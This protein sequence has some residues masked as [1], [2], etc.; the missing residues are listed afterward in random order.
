MNVLQTYLAALSFGSISKFL[1]I[2]SNFIVIYLLN[3]TIGKAG[4]GLFLFSISILSIVALIVSSGITQ[5]IIFRVSKLSSSI[6]DEESQARAFLGAG[7]ACNASLALIV[8]IL[9]YSLLHV[10]EGVGVKPDLISCLY[11]TAFIIFFDVI[12]FSVSAWC[13]GYHQVKTAIFLKELAPSILLPLFI[14]LSSA[15]FST[16]DLYFYFGLSYSLSY[17]V[18]P[19]LFL[20][21]QRPQFLSINKFVR[22]DDASYALKSFATQLTA[23]PTRQLDVVMVGAL[24]TPEQTADYIV[25]TKIV[26][27]GLMFEGLLSQL[28]VPR[29]GMIL[30]QGKLAYLEKEYS[31]VRDSTIAVATLVILLILASGDYVFAIFGNYSFDP[32]IYVLSAALLVRVTTGPSGNLL[33]MSGRPG[34]VSVATLL[35]VIV[36]LATCLL[37]IPDFG[38]LGASYALL[39]A[40]V[41]QNSIMVFFC[42]RHLRVSVFE[43]Q[44]I[45]VLVISVFALILASL[46]IFNS[47]LVAVILI[48]TILYIGSRVYSR[49]RPNMFAR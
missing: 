10:A 6:P 17:G 12:R 1:K 35:G 45:A 22:R 38:I 20:F 34:V 43:Y 40:A 36:H 23:Q 42:T 27:V 41:C 9:F 3:D 15:R 5:L 28:S 26:N 30:G 11:A 8:V 31:T 13:R 39:V 19:L 4:F 32:A 33:S 18:F 49:S 48:L 16:E 37:L 44:A 46:N 7:T 21:S 29:M 2:A 24:G 14:L 25:L 47:V